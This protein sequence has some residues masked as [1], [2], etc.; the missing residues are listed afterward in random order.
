MT[1]TEWRERVS[2][3]RLLC[4]RKGPDGQDACTGEIAQLMYRSGGER[5]PYLRGFVEDPESSGWSR[6]SRTAAE[7]MA[8][9][10]RPAYKVTQ[11]NRRYAARMP[12]IPFRLK[13]PNCPCTALVDAVVLEGV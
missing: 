10:R 12:T 11:E 9:G 8:V 1:A 6:P 7:K 2:N 13:C 3:D 5:Y 4:G